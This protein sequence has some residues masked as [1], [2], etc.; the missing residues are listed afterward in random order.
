[1]KHGGVYFLAFHPSFNIPSNSLHNL[2]FCFNLSIKNSIISLEPN[3]I[4]R[5]PP[6]HFT[7]RCSKTL[8]FQVQYSPLKLNANPTS[9]RAFKKQMISMLNT[10]LQ[11]WQ[12]PLLVKLTSTNSL[13][14][15]W[16]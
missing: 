8:P 9:E 2:L 16:F 5:S 12:D 4:H 14:L 11:Y 7:Y 13:L 1:M 3:M 6:S 10:L 15:L